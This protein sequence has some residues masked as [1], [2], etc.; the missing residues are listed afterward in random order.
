MDIKLIMFKGDG[1]RKDID[2]T[3]ST[4]VIGR[5]EECALRVPILA[6]SRKHCEL[7]IDGEELKVKDLGSSNGTYVNNARV[8]EATLK[9]GDRLMVG[10]II[11]TVQIDG[12]PEEIEPLAAAAEADSEKEEEKKD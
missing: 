10:P 9:A 7:S 5:G 4:T 3:S 2:V 6:V 1:Q 11:F 12:V 8:N